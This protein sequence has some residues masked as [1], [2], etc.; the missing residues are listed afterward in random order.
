[1]SHIPMTAPAQTSSYASKEKN[2]N[3]ELVPQGMHPAIIYGI[4]NIG[5]QDGEY[6]GRKTASNKLKITFEIPGHRQLY[7]K[8]DTVPSPS[9]MIMDFN[10][11][12]SK[13][14]KTG[15][16]SKLLLLIES[17]YG[18]LQKSQYLSFDISQ[19]AGLKVFI[20]IVHYIKMNGETGA[21]VDSVSQFNSAY[22]DPNTIVLTNNILVYSVQMGFE[23]ISFASL[24]YFYRSLIKESHEGKAHIAAGGR[25]TK[26][27]ENGNL[28]VDDGNDNYTSA[29][30]GK[31]VMINPQYTYEQLKGA[32]WTDQQMID[33]G[34]AKREAIQQAP[35][36]VP[37]AQ[38][39]IPTP[40]PQQQ[41]PQAQAPVQQAIFQQQYQQ[42]PQAQLSNPIIPAQILNP[43]NAGILP[44]APM[45]VQPQMPQAHV[46]PNQPMLTMIDKTISYDDYIKNGWNDQ[47]LI[48]HGKAMMMPA[49]NDAFPSQV[50]NVPQASQ[51]PNASQAQAIPSPQPT[52]VQLYTQ[53]PAAPV[54][55]MG[56]PQQQIPQA[57]GSTFEQAPSPLGNEAPVDDLPF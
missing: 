23:N 22:V 12:V 39:L 32:N 45:S 51:I 29:P 41:M 46:N 43:P 16:K 2:P 37:Q 55:Q 4:V 20:N 48:Q 25:F 8:D 13:N 57:P 1:M 14:E 33:N 19:L 35:I 30:L 26:L 17:L 53:T 9:A 54:Q 21:K 5:T 36:S 52:A 11:S 40:I 27:D 56:T 34:Y 15:K 24:P 31:L 18:P 49:Q 6:Q 3:L 42:V 28:I 38:A 44:Q 7:W 47:L 10:Y 50:P